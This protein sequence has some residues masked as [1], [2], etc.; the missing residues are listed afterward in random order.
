[1]FEP[2]GPGVSKGL[3]DSQILRPKLSLRGVAIARGN[4]QDQ[5]HQTLR[6]SMSQLSPQENLDLSV[7]MDSETGDPRVPSST[8]VLAEKLALPLRE[9]VTTFGAGWQMLPSHGIDFDA[10]PT[11]SG[12]IFG[13]WYVAGNPYQL[14]LR[15][16]DNGVEVGL[17]LA[18][19]SAPG[20]LRWQV[21]DRQHVAGGPDYAAAAGTAIA[22]MLAKRRRA[23]RYCRYCRNST[24]PEGLLNPDTCYGCGTDWLGIV[25]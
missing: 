17:P 5:R 2:R 25:Y 6:P 12:D 4:S 9:F 16:H 24:P 11:G 15:P 13:P 21:H 10:D 18:E 19:W 23:F 20:S 1:M 3:R 14:A 22:A 8:R 7:G